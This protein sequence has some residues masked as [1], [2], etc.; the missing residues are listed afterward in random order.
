MNF[1]RQTGLKNLKVAVVK[2]LPNVGIFVAE[3]LEG[4]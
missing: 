3:K 4:D 1:I 2:G